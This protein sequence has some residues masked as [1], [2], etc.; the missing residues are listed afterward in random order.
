MFVFEMSHNFKSV[1]E[2][3][4]VVQILRDSMRRAPLVLLEVLPV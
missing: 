2:A 1:V 4:E 3:A